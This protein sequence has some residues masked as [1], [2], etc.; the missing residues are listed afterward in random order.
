MGIKNSNIVQAW[1]VLLL[2]LCFGSA[3][4]AVH[5]VLSPA[6]EANKINETREKIPGLV[7][8]EEKAMALTQAGQVLQVAD[9]PVKVEKSGRQ[10]SYAVYEALLEDQRVGWV[11]KSSGQGYAD[12]IEL[13]VGLDAEAEIISGL[14]V[15]DQ[16]ETPG[17]GNKVVDT[18]W[19]G[20]FIGKPAAGALSVTKSGA[21][22]PL[23]IDAV[24]G[25]TIS[26]DA[27]V[28]IVNTALADV[29][30]VITKS[31]KEGY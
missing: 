27:V 17:L 14:F 8:G 7:M 29:R 22:S 28:Q 18:E 26:S 5:V 4:A 15:L 19:R 20:Q 9:L 24:T 3:L 10:V 16:K 6:I 12:K 1:L 2:C 23:E 11:V 13:L 30:P 31:N 25:A 21:S